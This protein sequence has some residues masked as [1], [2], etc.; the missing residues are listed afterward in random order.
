MLAFI[1]SFFAGCATI[2]PLGKTAE[3]PC[4]KRRE[5]CVIVEQDK[6][7]CEEVIA[8]CGDERVERAFEAPPPAEGHDHDPPSEL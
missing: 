3:D 7:F 5:I 4:W 2:P 8:R 6:K 1:L